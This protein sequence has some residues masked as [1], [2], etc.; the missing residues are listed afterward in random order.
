MLVY[1]THESEVWILSS[2]GQEI[3]RDGSHEVKVFNAI[4]ADGGI[5]VA[6]LQV[7]FIVNSL[8]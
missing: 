3:A 8:G 1:E 5:S 7:H 4:P 2:E 6:D